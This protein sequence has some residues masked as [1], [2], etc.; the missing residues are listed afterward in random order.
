[1]IGTLAIDGL[2]IMLGIGTEKRSMGKLVL[3]PLFAVPNTITC[4]LR[5]TTVP[6]A[7][8]KHIQFSFDQST[9]LA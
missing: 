1:M 6:T 9:Y 7:T 3:Q 2:V 5:A 4:Y 8:H